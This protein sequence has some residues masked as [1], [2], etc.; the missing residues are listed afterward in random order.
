MELQTSRAKDAPR[1]RA[2]AAR[3]VPSCKRS[4]RRKGAPRTLHRAVCASL[5]YSEAQV[6]CMRASGSDGNFDGQM[7]AHTRRRGPR[8]WPV[9]VPAV[10]RAALQLRPA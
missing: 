10:V 4:A 1:T 7:S 2:A 3:R 8:C 6:A 5:S 9:V